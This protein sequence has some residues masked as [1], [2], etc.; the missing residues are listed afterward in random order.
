MAI[1]RT[2]YMDHA[3]TTPVAQDVMTAMQPYFS[4]IYGNPGSFHTQG[5][6]AR[7]AVDAARKN[8]ADVLLCSPSELIFTSGGTESIVLALM[9]VM[10]GNR[11]KGNHLIT[12]SIEHEAVLETC[13][14]MEKYEDVQVSVVGVDAEGKVKLDVLENALQKKAL[15][16]SVGYA[17]NEIGTIQDI[18]KIVTLAHSYKALVHVD[19]CQ[20]GLLDLNVNHLGVDLLTLNGGKIYGPKGSGVLYK[21]K[22]VPMHSIVHGGGQE[23]GVRSG[24]EHVAG[25]VGI[26]TALSLIQKDREREMK[27]LV[28]LRDLLITGLLKIPDVNLYGHHTDRL[29]GNVHVGFQGID[30]EPLLIALN[31]V[32]IMAS[33]GSACTSKKIGPSHVLLAL[34]LSENDTRGVL[35]L[36]LGKSTTKK[37][38]VYVIGQVTAIVKRLRR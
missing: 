10:R 14:Y 22:G 8:V 23:G 29:P 11:E 24:T 36:T 28:E 16:V 13:K 6:Q 15:L 26:G 21:R 5:M 30:S 34:G 38:I 4:E 27:R 20:A 37:D 32:G 19:A 31:D 17:N 25:I 12:T 2:V 9:G 35:R 18:Q 3:S 7:D 33:A 1:H